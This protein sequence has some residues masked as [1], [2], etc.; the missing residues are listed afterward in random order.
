MGAVAPYH[1][2]ES[3]QNIIPNTAIQRKEQKSKFN[4]LFL[5]NVYCFMPSYYRKIVSWT[6]VSREPPVVT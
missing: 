5:L 6:I 2:L 1:C 4:V 3:Q